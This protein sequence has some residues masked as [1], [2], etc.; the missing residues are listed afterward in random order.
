MTNPNY[1]LIEETLK[2][3]KIGK[4]GE[5]EKKYT[6]EQKDNALEK[7]KKRM[8]KNLEDK[9]KDYNGEF[10]DAAK[11]ALDKAIKEIS[12]VKNECYCEDLIC[13]YVSD[14]IGE[15]WDKFDKTLD[16]LS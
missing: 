15:I 16:M 7:Y 3:W 2:K 1:D 4:Y 9:F 6:K 11:R 10:K 14:E 13:S 12:S 5:F 8:I